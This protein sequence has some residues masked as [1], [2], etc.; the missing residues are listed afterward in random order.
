KVTIQSLEDGQTEGLEGLKLTIVDSIWPEE[1]NFIQLEIDDAATRHGGGGSGGGNKAASRMMSFNEEELV[2]MPTAFAG[3][4][5]SAPEEPS[6][7][8]SLDVREVLPEDEDEDL[9]SGLSSSSSDA[10]RG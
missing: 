4:K 6:E 2:A 10:G 8:D 7:Q 5:S 9:L 3:Q 1:N